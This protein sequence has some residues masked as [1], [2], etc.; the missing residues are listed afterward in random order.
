MLL[1][2][3][4]PVHLHLQYYAAWRLGYGPLIYILDDLAWKLVPILEILQAL[5]ELGASWA[6]WQDQSEHQVSLETHDAQTYKRRLWEIVLLD[7]L[8]LTVIVAGFASSL[9]KAHE[10]SSNLGLWFDLAVMV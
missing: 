2:D 7:I 9:A 5:I 8:F 6:N 10:H 4:A 3:A 1:L